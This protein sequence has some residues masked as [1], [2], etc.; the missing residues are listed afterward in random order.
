MDRVGEPGVDVVVTD[1]NTAHRDSVDKGDQRERHTIADRPR[2]EPSPPVIERGVGM[3]VTPF[4]PMPADD[5]VDEV[6]VIREHL[7]AN[8]HRHIIARNTRTH[9]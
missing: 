3:A 2:D 4:A 7:D 6:E 1:R 8:I 5:R 9:R